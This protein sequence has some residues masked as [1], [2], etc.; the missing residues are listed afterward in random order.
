MRRYK[1]EDMGWDGKPTMYITLHK[2]PYTKK[3]ILN[4]TGWSVGKDIKITELK[5][6]RNL[7]LEDAE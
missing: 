6:Y 2:G 5:E 3:D 7:K 1:V 4:K